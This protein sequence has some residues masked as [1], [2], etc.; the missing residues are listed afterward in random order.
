MP[1]FQSADQ[2]G[3]AKQQSRPAPDEMD[4]GACVT[5]RHGELH[6]QR[7]GGRRHHGPASMLSGFN[8]RQ[9]EGILQAEGK[10]LLDHSEATKSADR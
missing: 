6:E 10:C 7:T 4:G 2:N 3:A 8:A 9:I 1:A 5:L